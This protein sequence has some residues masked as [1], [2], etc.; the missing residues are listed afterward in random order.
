MK[1][2]LKLDLS[3]YAAILGFLNLL[4]FH[5]PLLDFVANNVNKGLNGVFITV[6]MALLVFLANYLGFYLVLWLGRSVGK[7]LGA[8]SFITNSVCLYFINTYKVILDDTMMGNVFNTNYSEATSYWSPSALG[9]ILLAGVLP[10]VM[11]FMPKVNY[12]KAKRF[13]A[14]IG[15]TLAAILALALCN[16]SNW[17]WITKYDTELGAMLMPWSSIVNSIRYQNSVRERS[18][19]AIPLPDARIADSTK[20]A[21]IVIIGESSR[22]DH[23]SLY[24]YSRQTNPLLEKRIGLKTYPAEAAA[25][26]TTAGVKTILDHKATGEFYE[27][28]P[29]Y[30][31]R[32]GAQVIWRSSNWGEPPITVD[33]YLTIEELAERYGID[34]PDAKLDGTLLAGLGDCIA[35]SPKSKFAAFIHASTSHGPTYYLKYPAEY[36]RFTPA[37]REVEMSNCPPDEL[38]NAYDN[39]ILYTDALINRAIS[40]ADELKDWKVTVLFISDHGE[41]LGENGLYMHGVPR[42]IAPKEQYEIPFILWTNDPAVRYKDCDIASQYNVFHTVLHLLGIVSPVY[43]PEMDLIK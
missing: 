11:M 25:T 5:I 33:E 23:F 34:G 24:G 10:A 1:R 36:E 7:F 19:V 3:I 41:S 14:N 17:N 13:F 30:L 29:S 21:V 9:Y 26:Y 40:V 38:I 28:L 32:T 39:S 6:S 31:H 37:S 16:M 22:R 42:S 43:D 8:I 27:V 35:R 2:K 12:G 18:R 20:S 4:L 15:I